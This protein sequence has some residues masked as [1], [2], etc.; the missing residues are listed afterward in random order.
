MVNT[1]QRA[2]LATTLNSFF[3]VAT[4][5]SFYFAL[6]AKRR[7]SLTDPMCGTGQIPYTVSP[8][9]KARAISKGSPLQ[10]PRRMRHCGSHRFSQDDGAKGA[11][12]DAV[13]E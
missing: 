9:D 1:Q 11:S 10:T 13:W 8:G 5:A 2:H 3:T 4:H 7:S 6:Q 12:F